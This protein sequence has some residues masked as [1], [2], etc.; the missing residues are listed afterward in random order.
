MDERLSILSG[1]TISQRR[2]SW[3]R[4][5]ADFNQAVQKTLIHEGGFEN[6]SHDPGGAT[7]Y[8]ITQADMPGV[9]ITE[10]TPEQA[11]GYYK[12]HYWKPLFSQIIDQSVAEKL[13]DMGVLFG[14]STAVKLLQLTMQNEIAIVSDGQ[15]GEGTLAAVNQETDLLPRYRTMLIQHCVN[16][17][18][19][20]PES[21]VFING[22]I[23]RINS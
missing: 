5:M 7:K 14:V 17:V 10:I 11:V 19:N 8:G 21:G 4:K 1:V 3:R 15:F 16:I 22:W 9:N 2:R 18:N 20:R 13:F 6:T 12:E 23:S